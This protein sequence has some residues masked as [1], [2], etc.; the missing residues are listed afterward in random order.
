MYAEKNNVDKIKKIMEDV[1]ASWWED[2]MV[3]IMSG[4]V[5][6]VVAGLL[7]VMEFVPNE[8]LQAVLG[9]VCVAVMVAL[10]ILARWFKRHLKEKYVWP[11]TGYSK[12][13]VGKKP[14]LLYILA[15]EFLA[16]YIGLSLYIF[17]KFKSTN[18]IPVGIASFYLV[19]TKSNWVF[20]GFIGFFIFF[21]YFAVYLASGLKRFILTGLLALVSGVVCA[22]F[23]G[24]EL[25]IAITIM[26]V[27]GVYSLLN[28]IPR[29]VN[30]RKDEKAKEA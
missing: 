28:G 9:V 29:F 24:N 30:F 13:R 12:P 27:I 25:I 15:F 21:V 5:F 19:N 10:A 22:F 16:L 11:K 17:L 26:V 6:I 4:M 7:S 18:Q 8:K 14:S 20:A 3:E 1:R 2:G 23:S